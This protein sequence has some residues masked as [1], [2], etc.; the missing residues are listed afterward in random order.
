M[1][2]PTYKEHLGGGEPKIVSLRAIEVF[3]DAM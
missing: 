1:L 3:F 2:R